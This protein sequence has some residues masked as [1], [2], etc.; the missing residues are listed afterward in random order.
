MG[1][2]RPACKLTLKPYR[3][4]R[5]RPTSNKCTVKSVVDNRHYCPSPA[6][7][8]PYCRRHAY[9]NHTTPVTS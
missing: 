2:K 1:R 7:E 6:V 4:P 8:G 9:L 3:P 5:L